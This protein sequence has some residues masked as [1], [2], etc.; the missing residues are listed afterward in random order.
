MGCV[1]ATICMHECA[2]VISTDQ[3]SLEWTDG[4]DDNSR[5]QELL[6][7][8]KCGSRKGDIMCS[9]HAKYSPD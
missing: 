2:V 7:P 1:H 6:F 3:G 5:K 9:S 8:D 4:G